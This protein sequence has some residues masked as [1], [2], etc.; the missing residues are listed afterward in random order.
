MPPENNNT[1]PPKPPAGPRTSAAKSTTKSGRPTSKRMQ[2]FLRIALSRFAPGG[3]FRA[4]VFRAWI[5]GRFWPPFGHGRGS[6]AEMHLRSLSCWWWQGQG[7]AAH[8][9]RH[10]FYSKVL[11]LR[12]WPKKYKKSPR[13]SANRRTKKPIN[14]NNFSGLSQEWV[15][16]KFVYVF[17][18]SCA[19]R[20][21]HKQIPRKSQE[22]Y[23]TVLGQSLDSPGT[24]PGNICLCVSLLIGFFR[25]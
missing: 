11:V 2:G 25:P 23:V 18:F 22:N 10:Y 16:V 13:D 21:T 24:I 4:C 1:N 9:L 17:P 20:E 6:G 15:G 14:K 19:K 3:V 12:K 8:P 5:L 7:V